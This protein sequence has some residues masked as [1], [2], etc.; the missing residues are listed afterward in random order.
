MSIKQYF[1]YD[2]NLENLKN[3]NLLEFGKWK[4]AQK[5]YI[6]VIQW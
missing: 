5:N 4:G 6:A 2:K 1:P 3:Y